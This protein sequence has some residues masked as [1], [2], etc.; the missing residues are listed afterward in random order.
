MDATKMSA[1]AT[2]DVG[3]CSL[4]ALLVP[5]RE[6]CQKNEGEEGEDDGNDEEVGEYNGVLESC[7]DPYEVE[8]ILVD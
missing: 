2:C 4:V 3:S 8:R 7:G 1:R 6:C 5:A